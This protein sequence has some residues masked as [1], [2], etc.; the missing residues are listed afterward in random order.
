MAWYVEQNSIHNTVDGEIL[1]MHVE[2]ND[3]ISSK[4]FV[5]YLRNILLGKC[6][7]DVYDYIRPNTTES[8]E[9]IDN[10]AVITP[11]KRTWYI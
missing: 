4:I 7:D 3:I 6:E 9:V 5:R 10:L 2:E 11:K 8:K 1:E